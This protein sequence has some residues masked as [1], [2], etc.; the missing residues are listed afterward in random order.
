MRSKAP[1]V[2]IEQAVMLLVFALAAALCLR[3]FSWA[4]AASDSSAARDRAMMA[5]QS[6]A[7]ALK[8]CGGDMEAAADLYGGCCDGG[9]WTIQYDEQWN[10]NTVQDCYLVRVEQTET[11]LP[12]LGAA[13]VSVWDGEKNLV[14]LNTAWQEVQRYEP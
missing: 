11:Q 14:L 8:S 5:A 3:A 6:A 10:M 2:L 12:L 4:D 7:E 1:L 13:L 9:V